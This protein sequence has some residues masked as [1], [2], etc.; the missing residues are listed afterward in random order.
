MVR[1]NLVLLA[2]LLLQLAFAAQ[3]VAA[4][5]VKVIFDDPA[6]VTYAERVAAAAERALDVLVPLFGF[7]PPPITLRLENTTDVY[8]GLASPLPRPGVG[9]RLLFP[10]ETSVGYRAEDE[11]RFLLI[12]ELTHIMQFSNLAGRGHGLRLGLVGETVANVPPAWLVEGLAVWDESAFTAGGRRDDAL[13]RGLVQSAVFAGTA[14]SLAD[15]SLATYGA[16]PGGQ[17]EYLFGVGFTSYLI[18]QRGFGAIKRALALHNA[19][20]FIRPFEG[21]WRLAVGTD[22]ETEWRAWQVKVLQQAKVRA[23]K[24]AETA[25]AGTLRSESG[26]YT[27]APALSPDAS[28]LAW[29]GWPASIMLAQVDGR[30]LSQKRVLL[31]NRL[32]GSL[33][34]LDAHVLL[35]ARPV[36]RP[37]HTYSEVFTLDTRT[38]RETQLTEGARAKLPAPLLGGCVLYVTDDGTRSSLMQLCPG[39]PV[40]A[41][42]QSRTG[43]H[44]VGLATSRRGQ[45]ALSVWQQGWVDLAL[46]KGGTLR[47]LTHDAAQDLEPSWKGEDTLLFRSDRTAVFEL[48]GLTFDNHLEQLSRTLGGAF[49]PEAGRGGTWFVRLGGSGYNLA[50]LEDAPPVASSPTELRRSA[51]RTF[52]RSVPEVIP[53]F[54][55][56]SYNP[57]S[58]L[59]FYGWLPTNAG[60]SVSPP[61]GFL[62][63]SL[64][65]QD[66]S[67][68][69]NLRTTFGFDSSLAALS[70]FYGFARYDF[71]GGLALQATPPPLRYAVQIGAWPLAPHLS[72]KLETVAGA[73]AAVTARL[74][75]DRRLVSGGLEVGLVHVLGQSSGFVLDARAEGAVAAGQTDTWGY[76][77]E[78]WRVSATGLLSATGAAPSLGAWGDGSYTLP[79]AGPLSAL[80]RLEFGVRAGYRPAWPL[81]LKADADLAALVTVGSARSFPLKFRVGDGLYALERVTLEPRLRTWLDSAVH[82]GTDL[83]VSLDSVIGYGAPVS[84]SGTFGYSNALWTRFAVRLPL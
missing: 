66:D 36:R 63:L 9:L 75:E 14:P 13:T 81:P 49:T 73:K 62:E 43:V 83:T 24:V 27:R 26:W 59:G 40:Q 68:D 74:P 70:G 12:H 72:G 37:S 41:R 16:W 50:W 48:Y 7:T 64:L 58:S 3:E 77:T 8:N 46:L 21:S 57:L 42:W 79:L 39:Q 5:R 19:G 32:P 47:Y 84:L 34:W 38:G 55:V 51:L 69:H 29:V 65:A 82:L 71:G 30:G 31:D 33:E 76:R 56:F 10:T 61:G 28:Q 53:A 2:L 17:T 35:Y 6:E 1:R 44:V 45:V 4:P 18:R 25:R 60:V 80:G 11:L 22:L 15:A 20:G 54:P 78:G 52:L 67:L 23:Q